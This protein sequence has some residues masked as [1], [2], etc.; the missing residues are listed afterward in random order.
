MY[1]KVLEY[2]I[3]SRA[4]TIKGIRRKNENNDRSSILVP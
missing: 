3:E 4:D 2:T 1:R